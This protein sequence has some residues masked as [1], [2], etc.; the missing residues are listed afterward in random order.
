MY[1]IAKP[2]LSYNLFYHNLSYLCNNKFVCTNMWK[3]KDYINNEH[4]TTKKIELDIDS[5][6]SGIE[7]L[8]ES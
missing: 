7:D 1:D 2:I 6:V 5:N 8:E 4:G 3:Y